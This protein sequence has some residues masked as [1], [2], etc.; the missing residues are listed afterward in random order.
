MQVR[1]HNAKQDKHYKHPL[2]HDVS[3]TA[4]WGHMQ[5][6]MVREIIG[7]SK[8]TLRVGQIVRMMPLVQPTFGRVSLNTYN[9][10]VPIESVYH[11]YGSLRAGQ[12]YMG[13]NATYIPEKVI[14]TCCGFWKMVCQYMSHVV[15]IRIENFA[16]ASSD[17][18]SMLESNMVPVLGTASAEIQERNEAIGAWLD[19]YN[20][21]LPMDFFAQYFSNYLISESTQTTSVDGVL[22][23]S[24]YDW[25]ERVSFNNRDYLICGR[26]HESAKA[27]RKVLYG[28]GYKLINDYEDI[29]MLPLLAYYKAYFDLF[30]PKRDKT[31]KDCACAGLQEWCEQNGNFDACK[32]TGFVGTKPAIMFDFIYD[33]CIAYYTQSPDFVSAHI[34]GQRISNVAP[35]VF[36]SQGPSGINVY[37]GTANVSGSNSNTG[38]ITGTGSTSAGVSGNNNYNL[39]LLSPQNLD[40]LQR[41]YKR[42]N[43]KTAIGADIRQFLKTQLGVDYLD[44]DESYWIGSQSLDINISPVFSNAE[45]QEGYLGEFAAQGSGAT[46]GRNNVLTYEAKVDGFWI[47]MCAIVPD[48]R[49]AQGVD[50]NLKHV[51]KVDYFDSIY[52]SMTLLPTPKKYIF[53]EKQ[54]NGAALDSSVNDSFGNIPNYMEYC[55]SQNIVNGDMS[56]MSKRNYFLP[57]TLDKLLPYTGFYSQG[58]GASKTNFLANT[59]MSIIVN[60]SLWRYIGLYKWLGNFNRVFRDSGIEQGSV[61]S[62]SQYYNNMFFGV[63]FDDNFVIHNYLDFT[64]WNAKLPV[65]DSFQTGAFDDASI[66]VEKA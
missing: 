44:E 27:L 60:G 54:Y 10:F 30:Y 22:N 66:K 16:S 48:S 28:C 47:C 43:A 15:V 58:S 5:P 21:Y 26:F 7:N 57:F 34:T 6:L 37:T 49:F 56:L 23:L 12:T 45:T 13:A 42:I 8:N 38:V 4:E 25:V 17:L 39:N 61:T 18:I 64:C 3:T 63:G 40:I 9:V 53:A 50:M 33:L 2:P 62:T 19:S 14:S 35:E 52:D 24:R 51:K 11:P 55:T 20:P 41:V 36:T 29:T 1:V 59:P 46:D 65:S 32:S 31:W